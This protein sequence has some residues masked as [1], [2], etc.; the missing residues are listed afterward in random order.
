VIDGA[1]LGLGRLVARASTGLRGVQ[2]GLVRSYALWIVL[3]TAGLLLFLL[4]YAGR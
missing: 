2:S 3:G 1:A 4:L